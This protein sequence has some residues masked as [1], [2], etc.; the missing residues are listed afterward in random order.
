[1]SQ[2][3]LKASI[4]ELDLQRCEQRR[5]RIDHQ[6]SRPR[7]CVRRHRSY[8]LVPPR[9]LRL[10]FDVP[11]LNDISVASAFFGQVY[12][13]PDSVQKR[14]GRRVAEKRLPHRAVGVRS[15]AAACDR[16]PL[17]VRCRKCGESGQRQ[18][19]PPSPLAAISGWVPPPVVVLKQVQE[20]RA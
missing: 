1:M 2:H 15:R 18:V 14:R 10:R 13:K 8:P 6:N 12:A 3:E 19:R 7:H 17:T 20:D 4:L 16:L 5:L 9:P 11:M